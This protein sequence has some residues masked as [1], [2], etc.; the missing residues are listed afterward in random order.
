ML[1]ISRA[2]LAPRDPRDREA[3]AAVVAG[4]VAAP[5]EDVRKRID[6]KGAVCKDHARNE[7]APDEHLRAGRVQPRRVTLEKSSQPKQREAEQSRNQHVEAIEKHQLRKFREIADDAQFGAEVRL[8]R[9]PS[10]VAPDETRSE[11]RRA[12]EEPRSR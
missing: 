8:R 11:E 9:D 1:V 3:V 10:D 7:K 12:G 6:R 2:F 4:L 5:A